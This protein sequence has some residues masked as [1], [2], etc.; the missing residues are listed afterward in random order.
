MEGA[1]QSLGLGQAHRHMGMQVPRWAGAWAIGM[2]AFGRAEAHF[3]SQGLSLLSS[4]GTAELL[5]LSAFLSTA[6]PE[7]TVGGGSLAGEG[8][9]L[10]RG[11]GPPG[12]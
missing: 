11:G 10:P 1:L 7:G 5:P 12:E 8:Q 3:H 9:E 6:E 2:T 4:S